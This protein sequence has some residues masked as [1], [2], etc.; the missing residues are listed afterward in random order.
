MKSLKIEFRAEAYNIFNHT[1]LYYPSSSTSELGTAAGTS[2]ASNP[3]ANS[4]AI[5]GTFEPRI[6]QFG[7]KIIY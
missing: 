3:S 5:S 6:I 7:L 4:A 2:S 1:N